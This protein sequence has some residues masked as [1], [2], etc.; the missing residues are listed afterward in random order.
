MLKFIITFITIWATL[1]PPLHAAE[2][3]SRMAII[4]Y[5][6]VLVDTNSS[7]KGE[8]L[9]YFL[10]KDKKATEFLDRYQKG[11]AIRWQ[12]T[13]LGSIGT[14]LFLS[15]LFSSKESGKKGTYIGVGAGLIGLN[16]VIS[17]TLERNNEINL[18]RAIEEYNKRH[19][20]RIYFN[21]PYMRNQSS[22]YR[23]HNTTRTLVLNFIRE[24]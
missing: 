10:S 14:L 6:E 2:V 8:G 5:Q 9:R 1:S 3:C 17:K 20:P 19:I 16:I 11:T 7:Q 18:I 4:N 21:T 12:T 15:G 22:F 23:D 24:F 13:L